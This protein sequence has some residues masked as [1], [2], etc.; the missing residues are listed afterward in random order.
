MNGAKTWP[1]TVRAFSQILTTPF[2]FP[3]IM[4]TALSAADAWWSLVPISTIVKPAIYVVISLAGVLATLW[5]AAVWLEKRGRR[6]S[7]NRLR[8]RAII[9]F[10]IGISAFLIYLAGL[11]LIDDH[12]PPS[13]GQ[14]M[15]I[16]WL[17]SAVLVLA[18]TTLVG[19]MGG[20]MA[21]FYRGEPEG[22]V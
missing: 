5:S 6:L 4:P 9:L 8:R 3:A 16:A 18:V 11:P 14:V 7:R 1:M 19:A 22:P 12:L 15:A 13:Q 21:L 2:A 17:W 20:F 10:G